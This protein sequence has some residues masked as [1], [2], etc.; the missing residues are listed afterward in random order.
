VKKKI[1]VSV[2]IFCVSGFAAADIDL[3]PEPSVREL[4][5][6]KFPQ[7]EFR[8][9]FKK[10][11]Y[12]IPTGWKYEGRDR[13]MLAMFPQ[14]KAMASAKIEYLPTPGPLTLD[15]VQLKQF[16]DF[17]VT[18]LP[19]ES[20]VLVEP[21]VSPNPLLLNG[22]ATCELDILFLLHSQRMHTSILL[23]DLGDSQLRFTLMSRASDFLDLQKVFR[24]SWYS[25]QW[26]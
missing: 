22:H 17:A 6:C 5:G 8:D 18:F 14:G 19:L 21:T 2:A 3:T 16:K 26:L 7:L 15:E 23:V 11:A 24:Q 25:W 13:H 9:D 12:E 20:R 10:I 4:E 1:C